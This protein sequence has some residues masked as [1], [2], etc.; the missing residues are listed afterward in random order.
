MFRRR[1]KIYGADVVHRGYIA[2]LYERLNKKLVKRYKKG[3]IFEGITIEKIEEYARSTEEFY[4]PLAKEIIRK[5][6]ELLDVRLRYQDRAAIIIRQAEC[7]LKRPLFR[8]ERGYILSQEYETD[9]G[10]YTS[11]HIAGYFSGE[12]AK[13]R[14]LFSCANGELVESVISKKSVVWLVGF[15]KYDFLKSP[16]RRFIPAIWTYTYPMSVSEGGRR[17]SFDSETAVLADAYCEFPPGVTVEEMKK[18]IDRVDE[19][20]RAFD[21]SV[22]KFFGKN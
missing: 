15:S 18:V 16:A 10:S 21:E 6:E 13:K 12:W 20:A 5:I 9:H 1:P 2:E 8:K 17:A 11:P 7:V 4:E 14:C 3:S 19:Q 22:K